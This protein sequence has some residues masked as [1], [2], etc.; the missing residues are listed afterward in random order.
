MA[1]MEQAFQVLLDN[2]FVLKLSKCSFAQQQV[3]Y[4]GHVVLQKGVE[5]VAAKVEVVYQW[6]VPQSIK[7][8][9]S[10]LGLTGFYRRFIKGYATI[11]ALLVA[12]TTVDPFR[13]TVP[14]QIAFDRWKQALSEAPVLT[15][16]DF[17][18]PFTV[19]TD[20]SGVGMGAILS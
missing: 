4:L 18:L 17:Q 9:R 11:A 20:A 3:E 16:P 8:L 7:A 12:A 15:L 14:A 13:W 19:V 1:H 2:Q 10:F 6:S 5:P